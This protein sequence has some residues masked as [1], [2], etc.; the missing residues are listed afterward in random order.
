MVVDEAR[1]KP[2]ETTIPIAFGVPPERRS[3]KVRW[4]GR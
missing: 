4:P 3:V 1:A 2:F